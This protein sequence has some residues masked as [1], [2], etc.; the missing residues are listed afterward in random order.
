MLLLQEEE[1]QQ[2]LLLHL[3]MLCLLQATTAIIIIIIA[4]VKKKTKKVV[5]AVT[6]H[7]VPWLHSALHPFLLLRV[8]KVVIRH[9]T[10]HWIHQWQTQIIVTMTRRQLF[11]RKSNLIRKQQNHPR[12]YWKGFACILLLLRIATT[13]IIILLWTNMTTLLQEVKVL[14]RLNDDNSK[15]RSL[16]IP[17]QRR[18]KSKQW[19]IINLQGPK[20]TRRRGIPPLLLLL[21][22]AVLVFNK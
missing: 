22:F 15:A 1:K 2:Q 8:V 4:L 18:S 7:P 14:R 6:N 20:A 10:V 17:L 21:E 16:L 19:N 5:S 13:T 3:K 12:K 9:R 11:L